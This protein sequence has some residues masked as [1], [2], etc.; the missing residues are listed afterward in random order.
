VRRQVPNKASS[1][2]E[3]ETASLG[4]ADLAGNAKGMVFFFRNQNALDLVAVFEGKKKFSGTVR[5][6]FYTGNLKP[7]ADQIVRKSTSNRPAQIGH[8]LEPV[9]LAK[10]DPSENLCGA[11]GLNA[12][13]LKQRREL[14][15]AEVFDFRSGHGTVLSLFW[16]FLDI[17][18]Y[19]FYFQ[20]FN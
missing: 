19:K 6:D 16:I 17:T 15:P 9:R 5:G 11:V 12:A 1:G 7:P 4:A 20:E 8:I 3:T 14:V 10:I 2:G 13:G 18:F